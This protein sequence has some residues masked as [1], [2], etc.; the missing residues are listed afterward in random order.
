MH[1]KR[2]RRAAD[3][4]RIETGDWV[5]TMSRRIEASVARDYS[6]GFVSWN[7]MF[8]SSLNLSQSL[9]AY[10]RTNH[11]ATGAKFTPRDL[12]TGAVAIAEALWGK[13]K[14]VNGKLQT[15]NGDITKVSYV[16]GLSEA[17]HVLLKNI[18][19]TSRKLPGTVE[20]RRMMRFITQAYR[21]RYGTAI[22]VT[23]SPDESQNLLMIKF[24][25]T[26][27]NDPVWKH[28]DVARARRF[29]DWSSPD[30]LIDPC[31][32]VL[33]VSPTELLESLPS[34]DERRRILATDSLASVE[35][36]RVMVQLTF[37]Y[38]FGVKL[39]F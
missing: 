8:R 20:T 7:Y 38:L 24:S 10:E 31:E 25:R 39:L 27:R 19:H 3:A 28:A 12:E 37:K 33:S 15:V 17:A 35:G 23:F 5:R 32:C 1:K 26:R 36:F 16:P 22:F 9:Y 30:L 18:A 4:P 13:Y 21:I 34:Y 14:D 6:F 29:C 2:F 11:K